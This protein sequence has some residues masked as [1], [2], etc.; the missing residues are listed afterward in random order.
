MIV[1]LV[2]HLSMFGVEEVITSDELKDHSGKGPN[3]GRLVILCFKD[4]F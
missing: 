1:V 2:V 4:D 3:V